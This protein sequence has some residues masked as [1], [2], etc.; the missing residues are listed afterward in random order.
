MLRSK[1]CCKI[2]VLSLIFI[3]MVA[4]SL[5]MVNPKTYA[6]E[7]NYDEYDQVF[8][9][10]SR[11]LIEERYNGEYTVVAE[12]E[13]LYDI[14]LQEFG[15][16]YDFSVNGD[17]G[18]AVVVNVE[19]E[20]VLEEI[21]FGSENPFMKNCENKR[22][23]VNQLTYLEYCNDNY[24]QNG[25]E[26]TKDETEYYAD[27]AY[28]SSAG[29]IETDQETIY[30]TSKSI[31]ADFSLANRIPACTA[32]TSLG[33][34]ICVPVAG[35]NIIQ[36]Y[37]RYYTNLI[38]NYTPGRGAGNIYMYNAVGDEIRG[39]VLQLYDDMETNT[40]GA[41]VTIAQFKIGLET[42]CARQGYDITYQSCMSGGSMSYSQ[43]KSHIDAKT[44]VMIFMERSI[45]TEDVSNNN[46]YD[47]VENSTYFAN[48]SIVAFGYKEIKYTLSDGSN[49]NVNMLE[50][51]TGIS[52]LNNGYLN[53][54]KN[55][56]IDDAMAVIIN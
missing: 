54:Y 28:A 53:L 14:N 5:I 25:R 15:Y 50:V 18:F 19:N 2:L 36:Y 52:S 8:L 23:Y 22:I 16:I 46:G 35:A 27:I 40:T 10:S 4:I 9:Q 37:D 32:E 47:I 43:V 11:E 38:E 48:H 1:V 42:Y 17:N 31:I 49:R 55:N 21:F 41:G 30:Y 44:P 33:N 3:I 7:L 29:T 56:S 51:A 20:I 13:L 24:L 39:V 12:K 26:L 6:M 45:Y 34:N